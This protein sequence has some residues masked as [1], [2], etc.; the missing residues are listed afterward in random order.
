MYRTV[1]VDVDVDLSDFAT[2]DLIE[3]LQKR[4]NN[5]LPQNEL[6]SLIQVIYEKR[7]TGLDYQSELD[8]LIFNTLGR[9]I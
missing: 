3:E 4:S 5:R 2:E 8:S 1:S 6:E 7:R 9:I